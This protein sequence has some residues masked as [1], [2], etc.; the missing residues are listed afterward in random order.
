ML[1]RKIAIPPDKY[2]IERI[3]NLQMDSGAATIAA[4]MRAAAIV[5][6]AGCIVASGLSLLD[7]TASFCSI[8]PPVSMPLIKASFGAFGTGAFFTGMFLAIRN[9]H[10]RAGRRLFADPNIRLMETLSCLEEAVDTEL[11][12]L[13]R[14]AGENISHCVRVQNRITE[15]RTE[16][17]ALIRNRDT[18]EFKIFE[19]LAAKEEAYVEECKR[20]CS[21]YAERIQESKKIFQERF[22][23]L[24][25]RLANIR[26]ILHLPLLV[27]NHDHL[28]DT[29]EDDVRA[30]ADVTAD[31]FIELHARAPSAIALIAE[32]QEPALIAPEDEPP[33]E[34]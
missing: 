10:L 11:T 21:G 19:S 34:Q 25:A 28:Y 9:R 2:L 4:L 29:L 14:A 15:A 12:G 7:I 31:T 17:P 24:R 13:G 16:I 3:A 1:K 33:E 32:W 18:N 22:E 5:C 27:G 6:G 30:F 23:E 26:A 20:L 8:W